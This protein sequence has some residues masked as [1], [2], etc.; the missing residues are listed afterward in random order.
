MKRENTV[1][2]QPIPSADQTETMICRQAALERYCQLFARGHFPIMVEEPDGIF[3]VFLST[4]ERRK[5]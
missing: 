5:V 3:R 4:A 1:P 2:L